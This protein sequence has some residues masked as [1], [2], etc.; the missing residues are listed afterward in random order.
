MAFAPEH[1]V[2]IPYMQRTRDYY[3]FLGYEN[4]YRW[5][6]FVDVPF[7]PLRR[8]LA[9]ARLA[10]ITTAA[11]FQPGVGDQ[12]PGAPYNAAAKFYRVYSDSTARRTCASRTSATIAST[13]R[14]RTPT[15]GSR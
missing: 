2:P 8:P 13:P 10:L 15:R 9:E 3:L 4:A 12:G 14:P 5:A 1:D 6:H 7:A 11:P